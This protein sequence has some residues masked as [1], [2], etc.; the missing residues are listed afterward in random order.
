MTEEE[1]DAEINRRINQIKSQTDN[2]IKDGYLESKKESVDVTYGDIKRKGS[3]R[4]FITEIV[5]Y[6]ETF[7]GSDE[8]TEISEAKAPTY[9][10]ITI[11][12]LNPP[13]EKSNE[14]KF[15]DSS[16]GTIDMGKVV[17][18][19]MLFIFDKFKMDITTE[20]KK[21]SKYSINGDFKKL[22]E[23]LNGNINFKQVEEEL[24]NFIDGKASSIIEVIL[25]NMLDL[26]GNMNSRLTYYKPSPKAFTEAGRSRRLEAG[27]IDTDTAIEYLELIGLIQ[28]R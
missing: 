19:N 20:F 28:E 18:E 24:R 6:D 25:N 10:L 7:F 3:L 8:I 22:N 17:L 15:V 27:E 23:L 4:A 11:L 16:V 26:L 21:F 12:L 14:Y 2:P 5:E 9:P 13:I 1:K